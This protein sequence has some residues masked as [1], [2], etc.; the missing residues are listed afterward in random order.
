MTAATTG[1]TELDDLLDA[2]VADVKAILGTGF[3]GAYLQGSFALGSA[4]RDSDV[5]FVIV[6][7]AEPDSA[8]IDRLQA[9][10]A[11]L[12]AR[13]VSWA[14]H[15]EGSYIPIDRLRSVD[16]ARTP[17]LF[18]DNGA[19]SLVRDA[20]CNTAVVRWVLRERGMT[21]DGPEIASL[22]DP[23]GIED[24]RR[25]GIVALHEYA[26]WADGP[27]SDWKQTYLVLTACRILYTLETGEVAP[28]QQSGDWALGH[29]DGRWAE[30]IR[31]ALDRRADPWARVHASAQPAR[32]ELTRAF[33]ASSMDLA[34]RYRS[35]PEQARRGA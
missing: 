14:H 31:D 1:F 34:D 28:K 16:P 17:F 33:L 4:D 7:T 19:R 8:Q 10:H 32:E 9:M 20:H 3:V 12:F 21:L 24:L 11:R 25:E 18:L 29:L 23:V 26:A 30:L 35:E 15:L 13:E 27:M 6:M 5:D 22:I 2:L